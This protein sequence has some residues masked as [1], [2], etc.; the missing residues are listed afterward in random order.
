MKKLMRNIFVLLVLSAC[1]YACD[2][3]IMSPI[4]TNYGVKRGDAFVYSQKDTIITRSY[5]PQNGRKKELCFPPDDFFFMVP[6][7]PE[8]DETIKHN[9]EKHELHLRKISNNGVAYVIEGSSLYINDTLISYA[10]WCNPKE[11][12]VI[13]SGMFG[14]KDTVITK[15]DNPAPYPLMQV[16]DTLIEYYPQYVTILTDTLEHSFKNVEATDERNFPHIVVN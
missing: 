16:I 8:Q 3:V 7:Y 2:R 10:S 5:D 11:D 1:L 9:E 13:V 4:Q 14:R 12:T 15:I 6:W